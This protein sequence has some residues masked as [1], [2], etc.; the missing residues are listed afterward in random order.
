MLKELLRQFCPPENPFSFWL[1]AVAVVLKWHKNY[2]SDQFG[3]VTGTLDC[4]FGSP[5]I[6]RNISG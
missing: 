3:L 2:K 6:T 4:G 1:L 5:V